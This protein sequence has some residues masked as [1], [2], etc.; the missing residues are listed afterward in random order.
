MK[1]AKIRVEHIHP[2]AWIWEPL[3][4]DPSFVLR[5]MFGTKAVYLDGKLM[6]CF[7]A[8]KAP[9]NGVLVAT[10][11]Q[12]HSSLIA[13]I[14][15]LSPHPVLTKWLYLSESSDSFDEKAG[16]LI[17]LAR[18]GDERLG[19]VPPSQQLC[20]LDNRVL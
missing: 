11:R 8:R 15:A 14:P 7:A 16:Y 13:E 5:A 10:S 2:H 4:T 12:H 6:F 18:R 20:E 9:W 3:E 17:R 19:V 1:S